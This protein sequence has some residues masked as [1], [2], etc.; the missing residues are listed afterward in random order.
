VLFSVLARFNE[1]LASFRRDRFLQW[2]E[3]KFRNGRARCIEGRQ[4]GV[5]IFDVSLSLVCMERD[6]TSENDG[7]RLGRWEWSSEASPWPGSRLSFLS[8]SK[9]SKC[10]HRRKSLLSA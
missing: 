6:E 10:N 3:R 7:K 1:R 2:K 9:K 8:T 5:S 4:A